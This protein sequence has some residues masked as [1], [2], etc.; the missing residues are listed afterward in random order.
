M[1][2]GNTQRINFWSAL[3]LLPVRLK[4][5]F[6]SCW[7]SLSLATIALAGPLHLMVKPL[8]TNQVEL[9]FGPVTAGVAYEVMVRTNGPTGHWIMFADFYGGTNNTIS[10]IHDLGSI[11]GLTLQSFKNWNFVAGRRAV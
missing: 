3:S 8:G 7:L 1:N 10:G 11:Q 6:L 4:Y 9:T 2:L 5:Y